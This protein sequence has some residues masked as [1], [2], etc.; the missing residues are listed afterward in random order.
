MNRY[1]EIAPEEMN[2]AQRRAH[3]LIVAGRRG[4]FSLADSPALLG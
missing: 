4:R 3:D 2:P 1:R